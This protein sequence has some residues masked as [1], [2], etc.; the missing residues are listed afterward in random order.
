VTMRGPGGGYPVETFGRRKDFR[1]AGRRRV[2]PDFYS[3]ASRAKASRK[4]ARDENA[5]SEDL[6]LRGQTAGLH[7]V[8]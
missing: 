7:V 1:M 2:P 8:L 3:G 6:V 4:L 5:A